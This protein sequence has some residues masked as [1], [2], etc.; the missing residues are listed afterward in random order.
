MP[1]PSHADRDVISAALRIFGDD[2]TEESAARL[3]AA[4]VG[5][6]DLEWGGIA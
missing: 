6:D 3:R 2:V 4:F 1:N 5:P